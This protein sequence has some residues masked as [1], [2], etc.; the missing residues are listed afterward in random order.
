MRWQLGRRSQN[1]EDRRGMGAPGGMRF[2]GGMRM[3]GG[4]G[5]LVARRGARRRDRRASG[6]CCCWRWAGCSASIRA[7]CSRTRLA[8]AC[9]PQPAP[10]GTRPPADDQAAAFVSVVLGRHRGHLARA[11][12]AAGRHLPRADARAVLGRGRIRPAAS[13]RRRWA[14]STARPTRSCTSTS[15]SSTSCT[16]GSG[17]PA[18]SPRPT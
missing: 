12:R 15:P 11:V 3:P 17:R 14:R 10:S 6:C 7:F 5:A 13:P 2:P 16:A 8:P 4:R 9:P 1:V 18:T